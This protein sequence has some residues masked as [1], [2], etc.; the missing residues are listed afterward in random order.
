MN[1][2]LMKQ[3]CEMSP[4]RL[5]KFLINFLGSKGYKVV[6]DENTNWIVA[7]GR[8][9]LILCAHIDTIFYAQPT[10]IYVDVDAHVLW[11]PQGLGAD[12]RAGVYAIMDILLNTGYR[13]SIIF[14]NDEE[15]G[16]LGAR[17][18]ID[19]YPHLPFKDVKAIIQLDR[20]GYRDAVYYGC[21]NFSFEQWVSSF[22][23][24]TETGSFSD[25]SVLC[26]IWGIAGVNL[27]VGYYNEHEFRE[28][29]KW[30]ELEDV[31]LK[32]LLMLERSKAL[33][34]L[35]EYKHRKDY[36]NPLFS[37]C[38]ICGKEII[39][40][41]YYNMPTDDNKDVITICEDC[42]KKNKKFDNFKKI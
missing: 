39:Y 32:V 5:Y 9:P 16:C 42:F 1:I 27:S 14:T 26:P 30:D 37:R 40:P 33:D 3:L 4:Q 10:N 25:I 11:S 38:D 22:G 13:P 23:F 6:S 18:L 36:V 24:I 19:R 31:I 17:N 8:D 29:L 41:L 35:F 15:L 34:E 20:R 12:D 21:D 7:Q 2:T 28:Y